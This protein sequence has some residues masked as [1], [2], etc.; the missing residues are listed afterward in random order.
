SVETWD[1]ARIESEGMGAFAAVARA[2]HEEPRLIVLR[3]EP[4]GAG[5]PLVAFVGKGVTWDSG[6]YWLKPHASMP[7]EKYDMSGGAAVIEAIAAIAEL[8]LPIR[9][10]GVVGATENALGGGAMRPSDVLRALDGTTI[11]MNNSDAEGRLILADCLT[12]ARRQGAERLVDV[13]T[14]TGGAVVALGKTF[15]ALLGNDEAWAAE[16]T[17]A[18]V[19]SG[20]RV[21]RLPL[22]P[23][24][25][26]RVRGR[27]AQLT[28]L[29]ENR[30]HASAITAAEFLHH[31][32]GDVP[33]A[34]LDIAGVADDVGKPY[35]PRGGTG[36]G[37]RLLVAL[38]RR[39]ASA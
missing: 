20:E 27:V 17:A 8:G 12:Y 11:E 18:A 5:G 38:A 7:A 14:L 23:E 34:H 16:V 36:W 29:A 15:A 19:A 28:N 32:A 35:A 25:A 3:H 4:D 33:W 31:F 37:V 39:L 24:Y 1:R 21:W 10:L 13:A 6:G 26:E 22:D 30:S 2:A 9:I